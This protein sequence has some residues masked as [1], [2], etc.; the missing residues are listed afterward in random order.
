MDTLALLTWLLLNTPCP[1]EPAYLEIIPRHEGFWKAGSLPARYHNP[2]AL[3]YARQDGATRGAYNYA[4]FKSDED[5]FRAL[6][7][8]VDL[9]VS[10]HAKLSVAW[11]YLRD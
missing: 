5:G 11:R 9:K 8:D 7:Q 10:R 6:Q 4:R 3:R 2:G 1:S